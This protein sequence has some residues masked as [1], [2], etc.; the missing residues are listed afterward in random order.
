MRL[1][2]FALTKRQIL[3]QSKTVTRRFGWRHIK[4]GDLVQ[5]VEKAMGLKKGEKPVKLGPPIRI[6]SMRD[7]M[8][9]NITEDDCRREGFPELQPHE[10]VSMLSRHYKDKALSY[11]TVNRIEFEYTRGAAP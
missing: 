3:D 2:S 1:M 5:P 6:V 4:P 7:E 8:L 10:F 9:A 11:A